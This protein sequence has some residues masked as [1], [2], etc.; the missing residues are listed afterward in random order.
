MEGDMDKVLDVVCGMMIDP[1]T[2]AATATYEARVFYFCSEDCQRVFKAD[3]EAYASKAEEEPPYTVTKGVAAP[4]F[5][6][7]V[8]GGLEYEPGPDGQT[9]I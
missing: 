6:S 9:R 8:S 1:N 4:K 5:G 7:A 2:A 3:P